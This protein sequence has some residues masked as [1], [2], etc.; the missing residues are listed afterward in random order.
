MNTSTMRRLLTILF[1]FVSGLYCLGNPTAETAFAEGNAA[2]AKEDYRTAIEFYE[3]ALASGSSPELHYNLGTAYAHQGEWGRA[4]LHFLKTLALNPNH[5]DARAHLALVRK[6][7]EL[8]WTERGTLERTATILPLNTWA[9]L[10]VGAFWFAVFL[11]LIRRRDGSVT[12]FLG[13]SIS[14][15]VVLIA[16]G[17]LTVYHVSA[18]R[19]V[20]LDAV[21]MRVAPTLSSPLAAEVPAGLQGNVLKM[22]NGFYLVRTERGQ[23]GYL[24]PD[25][26]A[27][28]WEL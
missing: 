6:R 5:A 9:W 8:G 25:E 19:G 28:V 7:S 20:V 22:V 16:L 15:G 3:S 27:T 1:L 26:F 10:A 17:A 14:S 12:N 13:R 23:E 2:F 21:S 4:S 24:T 18:H 11:W